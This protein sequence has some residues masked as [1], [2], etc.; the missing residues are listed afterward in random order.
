MKILIIEA[1]G[2]G[3]LDFAI[4]CKCAG[5]TVR[6]FIRNN[7]DGSRSEVGDGIIERVGS[8]EPHMG[9]ADL[10]FCSD[11]TF[12]I[13]MLDHYRAKGYPIISPNGDAN[14]W[15]QRR[16]VGAQIMERAGI[17]TIPSKTFSKYDEAI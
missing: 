14:L 5:H 13:T 17:K 7:K 4:R 15:E 8:W 12:Y 9:W 3:S 2:N 11:N 6:M 1:G 16:D 10:I